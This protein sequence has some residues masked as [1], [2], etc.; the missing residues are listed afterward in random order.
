[1]IWGYT[2]F[3]KPPW[4]MIR[5]KNYSIHRGLGPNKNHRFKPHIVGFIWVYGLWWRSMCGVYKP[6]TFCSL[7]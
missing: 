3:R 4:F 7:A 6:T 1:M 2:Y 5:K